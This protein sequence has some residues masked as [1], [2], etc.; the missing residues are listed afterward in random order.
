MTNLLILKVLSAIWMRIRI[1]LLVATT[2]MLLASTRSE[3]YPVST[4][5]VDV[6][7][8]LFLG[9]RGSSAKRRTPSNKTLPKEKREGRERCGHQ[10][11]ERTR[12]DV[13]KPRGVQRAT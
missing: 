5:V 6:R 3:E 11:S 4:L 10:S 13:C 2:M 12:D 7:S 8:K 1:K 9:C